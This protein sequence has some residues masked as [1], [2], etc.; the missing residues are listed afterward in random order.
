MGTPL[1]FTRAKAATADFLCV[2][3]M[4][5][6]AEPFERFSRVCRYDGTDPGPVKWFYDDFALAVTSI[7]R[8]TPGP[9]APASFCLLSAEGDV[10]LLRPPFLREKIPGAGIGSP[11]SKFWGRMAHLRVIG[12]HLYACGDGGQIYRRT[13]S[14]FGA[15]RWEHLDPGLLQDPAARAQAL[16]RAPF[17]PAADHKIFYCVNGPREDEIYI[18]GTDGTVL[19]W[20][21]A[22]FAELP[23]VTNAALTN[24]LVES[25]QSIL[26]C[27]RNGTLLRGNRRDGFRRAVGSGGN[28]MFMSMALFDGKVYLASGADPRGLF[29]YERGV[30]RQV[31]SGIHPGIRDAHTVDSIDGVLWVVGS[32]DVLRFDGVR[33][34]RIDH[35][36]N[37]PIR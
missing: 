27:G 23:K 34:E 22:A 37:P 31:S 35:V 28:Q 13:G 6:G 24:I 9:S 21:G 26:I 20:D 16:L 32:K 7:T 2:A 10:V 15:G 17:S 19:S 14:D 36:D 18:A 8:F 11:D 30:L 5:D 33:W 1:T 4:P 29:V 12:G 25:E 3:G